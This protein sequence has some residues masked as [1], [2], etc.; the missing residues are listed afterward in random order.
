M[1]RQ[2]HIKLEVAD[3]NT[4][5]AENTKNNKRRNDRQRLQRCKIDNDKRKKDM[6]QKIKRTKQKTKHRKK[7]GVG[8][9]R[10]SGGGWSIIKKMTVKE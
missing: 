4:V 1:K 8:K 3:Q 7:G 6:K 10:E 2:E 5:P 9:R